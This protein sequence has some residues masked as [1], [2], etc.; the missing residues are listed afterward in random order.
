M[1]SYPRTCV[2]M[3]QHRPDD[4]VDSAD[5]L[6][7]RAIVGEN[8]EESPVERQSVHQGA[9]RSVSCHL[10][11]YQDGN[12]ESEVEQRTPCMIKYVQIMVCRPKFKWLPRMERIGM[13][14]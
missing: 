6:D 5:L 3:H 12:L 10:S 11:P 7:P 14:Q 9:P 13:H 4:F 2:E 8:V 1:V